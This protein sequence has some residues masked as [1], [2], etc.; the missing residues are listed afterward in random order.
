[1]CRAV[2]RT[3]MHASDDSGYF[4]SGDDWDDDH[5]VGLNAKLLV[6]ARAMLW[7]RLNVIFTK[8]L[9]GGEDHTDQTFIERVAV[10]TD[11]LG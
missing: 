11:E 4:A 5:G 7:I 9:A 3:G 1:M 6:E 8:R 10:A 2:C